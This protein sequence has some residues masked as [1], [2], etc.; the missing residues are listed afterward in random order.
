[1][2]IRKVLVALGMGLPLLAAS[3]TLPPPEEFQRLPHRR[4]E[5]FL[6]K[7][8]APRSSP[9]ATTRTGTAIER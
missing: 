1:M 3:Q 4:V 7:N 9:S 2:M 8:L 6:A 5:K